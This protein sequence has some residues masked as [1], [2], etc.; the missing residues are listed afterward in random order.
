MVLPS[1]IKS[2]H[3]LDDHCFENVKKKDANAVFFWKLQGSF[4]RKLKSPINK[5]IHR[6]VFTKRLQSSRKRSNTCWSEWRKYTSPLA[7]VYSFMSQGV[8]FLIGFDRNLLAIAKLL[9]EHKKLTSTERS[10]LPFFPANPMEITQ[11][12]KFCRI[13]QRVWN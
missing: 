2:K 4:W 8:M 6:I 3:T 12:S 7:I 10:T 1:L 5:W 11:T 9:M 13:I